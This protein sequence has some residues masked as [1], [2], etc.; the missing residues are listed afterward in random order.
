MMER[1]AGGFIADKVFPPVPVMKDS[2]IIPEVDIEQSTDRDLTAL[3]L[4]APGGEPITIDWS[5]TTSHTYKCR[6]HAV[7]HPITDEE[8][9]SA[10]GAFQIMLQQGGARMIEKELRISKEINAAAVLATATSD[11]SLT[12]AASDFFDNP[13]ATTPPV[14]QIV[15]KYATIE[16]NSG[17]TP[18]AVWCDELVA[19][20]IWNHP[21]TRA[22]YASGF[23]IAPGDTTMKAQILA[24]LLG[25]ENVFISRAFYNSGVRNGTITNTRVW[26]E[27]CYIGY[28][29]PTPMIPS[30]GVGYTF[31]WSF[32]GTLW[33]DISYMEWRDGDPSKRTSYISG[34]WY[35]DQKTTR[36]TA[37]AARLP[38]YSLS[39]CLT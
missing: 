21:D 17:I 34:E 15:A 27:L 33:N 16:S 2:D 30:M 5:V 22:R 4:R 1:P 36:P 24:Q 13:A 7:R 38:L 12:A 39:N 31:G 20:A 9:A 6:S 35:Y 26:G 3:H 23:Q 37:R 18:N 8:V 25:V 32:E 11:G 14:D 19:R 10:D 28:I 29:E